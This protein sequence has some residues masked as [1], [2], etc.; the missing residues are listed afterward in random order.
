MRFTIGLRNGL[1]RKKSEVG[2]CYSPQLEDTV[3]K[4][5]ESRRRSW[6]MGLHDKL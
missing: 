3:P 2:S 1:E 5:S 6:K 4:M